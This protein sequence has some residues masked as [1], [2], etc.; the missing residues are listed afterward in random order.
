MLTKVFKE[1][2]EILTREESKKVHQ[3]EEVL[4]SEEKLED[5]FEN[6]GAQL[7]KEV[8][9]KT[10]DDAGEDPSTRDR[11]ISRMSGARD[12]SSAAHPRCASFGFFHGQS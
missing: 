8:A 9:S 11:E 5:K 7:V 4:N 3:F 1:L 6:I 10:A 2:K 12:G